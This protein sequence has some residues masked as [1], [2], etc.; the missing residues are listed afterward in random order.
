MRSVVSTCPQLLVVRA[1]L[2]STSPTTADKPTGMDFSGVANG[3]A[4]RQLNFGGLF[5]KV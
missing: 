1:G 4:L 2:F 5:G 3:L